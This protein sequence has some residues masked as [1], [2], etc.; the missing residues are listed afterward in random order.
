MEPSIRI[1]NINDFI[2]C[3]HSIYLH[4]VYESFHENI[5]K[6]KPQTAGTLAHET[7]DTKTYSSAKRY[8]QG[9]SI[10]SATYGIVGKLDI[11]DREEQALIERKRLIKTVYDGYRFQLY[12][13]Y[14]CLTEMGY[15]VI[16]LFLHSLA[17][18]KRYPI[19]LP[20]G[21][22]KEKFFTVLAKLNGYQA[23]VTKFPVNK[24]KCAMCIYRELCGFSKC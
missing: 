16:K 10:Y 24:H 3:P 9:I 21:E 8:L 19:P 12:A 20:E 23:G 18:N 22:E 13:Q 17:N 1:S 11:Y 2:F 4:G 7:V 14:Y 15:P 6:D 5:Y